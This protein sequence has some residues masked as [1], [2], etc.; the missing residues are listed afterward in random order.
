MAVAVAAD[1]RAETSAGATGAGSAGGS[2]E[3]SSSR[4]ARIGTGMFAGAAAAVS[5]L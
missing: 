5:M 2:T 3:T 4:L 1:K